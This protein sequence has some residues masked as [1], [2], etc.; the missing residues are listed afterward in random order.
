MKRKFDIQEAN[1]L[2]AVT[3]AAGLL[4]WLSVEGIMQLLG[5]KLSGHSLFA[6]TGPFDNPGPYGGFIGILLC[7]CGSF[8]ISNWRENR[9]RMAVFACAIASVPGL[10]ALAAS[11]SRAAWV[12]VLLAAIIF[13]ARERSLYPGRPKWTWKRKAMLACIILII[14]T[15]AF[16]MK[17][18]SALGRLHIW[19]ME[20]RVIK[21]HPLKGVG[22]EYY[23]GAYGEAQ[24]EFFASKERSSTVQRI[25]GC[26]EYAFNEYLKFG[27]M[28][29]LGGLF[30]SFA[31]AGAVV[32]LLMRRRSALA[33]GAL[34]FAV[35]AAGSYPLSLWQ[36]R[37]LA[38]VFLVASLVSLT[39]KSRV[40]Y[41][42][43][44]CLA[45]IAVTVLCFDEKRKD[46]AA[47]SRNEAI[48][49]VAQLSAM[50]M[51]DEAVEEAQSE[52]DLCHDNFRFLY[53]YGYALFKSGKYAEAEAVLKEGA[54]CSCDP[55][56]H[57]ILGRCREAFGDA[58]GAE[59][60]YRHAHRMVPS[61][62][63]PLV[64]LMEMYGDTGR[65]EEAM[66][67]REQILSMP[68]N[69]RNANMIQ[70]RERA[71]RYVIKNS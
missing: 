4:V 63:Y 7:V 36:F 44:L 62:L 16:L 22:K 34:A 49:F 10:L 56:F 27:M 48:S 69:A 71:E 15:G 31:V 50:E 42:L 67:L 59:A 13:W 14:G 24:A 39:W 68:I 19:R 21:E 55:M 37:A 35:F 43:S 64:L 65:E 1:E 52:F 47:H 29:G 6:V 38:W 20:L 51:Y 58:D 41:T 3:R 46:D 9:N 18:E 5:W 25:A 32:F 60:E 33:Y 8:A 23:L 40:L 12:G 11:W 61:R 2:A 28:Y 54:Q 66:Q 45:V 70:L 30:L 17:K 53:D 26:P 57:V